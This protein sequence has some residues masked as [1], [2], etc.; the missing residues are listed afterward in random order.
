MPTTWCKKAASAGEARARTDH[1]VRRLVR[2]S[3]FRAMGVGDVQTIGASGVCLMRRL[4][5][6]SCC[7]QA[8]RAIR[9]IVVMGSTRRRRS[10]LGRPCLP[11]GMLPTR[12]DPAPLRQR[13]MS[14]EVCGV[15]S[16]GRATCVR[17][18]LRAAGLKR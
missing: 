9:M 18:V 8:S 10:A 13:R 1:R 7:S 14:G 3:K 15:C 4:V 12:A 6:M 2:I 11:G 16:W 17:G 5:A